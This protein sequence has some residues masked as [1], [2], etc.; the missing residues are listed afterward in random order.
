L[1]AG[2]PTVKGTATVGRRTP[3]STHQVSADAT[4]GSFAGATGPA[5]VFPSGLLLTVAKTHRI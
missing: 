4:R 3:W 1:T 2:S 5:P